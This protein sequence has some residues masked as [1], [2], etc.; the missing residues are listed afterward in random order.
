MY[1]DIWRNY[2]FCDANSFHFQ[3]EDGCELQETDTVKGQ[4]LCPDVISIKGNAL[5]FLCADQFQASTFHAPAWETPQAFELL[6]VDSFK[7]G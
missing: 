6:K 1:R 7:N 4:K 2:L 3:E 5:C